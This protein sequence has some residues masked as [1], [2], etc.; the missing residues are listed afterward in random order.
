MT[1]FT[2]PLN[3]FQR[4]RKMTNGSVFFFL[5]C[6]EFRV[7]QIQTDQQTRHHSPGQTRHQ[8]I[9]MFEGLHPVP[10]QRYHLVC[11]DH[12]DNV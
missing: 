2:R 8:S 7:M 3:I 4:P 1:L 5:L 12:W 9:Q 11:L 10:V 6:A